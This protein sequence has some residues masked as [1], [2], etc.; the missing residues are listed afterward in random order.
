MNYNKVILVG[1][2]VRE[3]EN[4]VLPSGSQISNLVVA[5]N[6]NYRLQDGSWKEESHFF[7]IKVFGRLA[8]RVIPQLSKGDLVLIEGRLHQDR[9]LDKQ[10]GEP[11]SKIRIVALDIKPLSRSGRVGAPSE[12]EAGVQPDI[13]ELPPPEGETPAPKEEGETFDELEELLFG[14]EEKGEKQ[15]GEEGKKDDLDDFDILL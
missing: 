11:R 3:P 10:T 5:Y 12:T 14:D 6:R 15:K 7:E 4:V 9:W 8:E 1:R 13:V 2:L